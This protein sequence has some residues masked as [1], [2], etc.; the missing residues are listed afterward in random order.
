MAWLGPLPLAVAV[1]GCAVALAGCATSTAGETSA[2]LGAPAAR[3]ELEEHNQPAQ[4]AP[5]ASRRDAADDPTEPFS[6]TYGL[7]LA[8][9]LFGPMRQ[10]SSAEEEAL[11][12]RAITEHEMRRP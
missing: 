11:I 3:V 12:A 6:R 7:P 8:A 4:L 2:S 9:R 1:A 5:S 10:M